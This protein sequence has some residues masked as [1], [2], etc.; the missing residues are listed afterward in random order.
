MFRIILV[1][2]L[3]C[4]GLPATAAEER[5]HGNVIYAV[6]DNWNLGRLQDGIQTLIS[7]RPDEVCEYCYIYLALGQEKRGSLV[8]WVADQ[9]PLFLDEDDQGGITVLQAPETVD[10]GPVKAAMMGLKTGRTMLIVMGFELTDRFEIAAF[11]GPASDEEEVAESVATFQ[12]QVTPMLAGLRFVSEGAT[13]LMP[14]PAPG[15][16]SGLYWGFHTYSSFG[17][18]LTVRTEIGQ[19]RLVFWS[20]GHFYDGTPPNGLKP[21]DPAALMAVGDADFGTYRTTGR[22]LYLTYSNG[23]RERLTADADGWADDNTTLSPVSPLADGTMIEGSISSFFYSGFS[24]GS[25]VSGGVSSSSETTFLADGTYTGSSFG[26]AFGNFESGGDTTGG[27][28]TSGGDDTGGTY[29]VRDG[30][31]I[32]YPADG[33][34]PS[35]SMIFTAGDDILIDNQFLSQE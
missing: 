14:E 18:D 8:R 27:F 4:L 15:P 33:S 25:G 22:K 35:R 23:V 20:D 5:Q 30:L 24:P 21:L 28:A 16:L 3:A 34:Q 10:L 11:A 9:A 19:R 6:P 31:L 17:L 29:Q 1:I 13:P 32:Q 26:G 7:D 2:L 12:E